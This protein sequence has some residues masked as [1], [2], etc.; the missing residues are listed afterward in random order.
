LTTTL[1]I[2]AAILVVVIVV[3]NTEAVETRLLFVTVSMPRAV[4]LFTTTLLG[5]VIGLLAAWRLG[6]KENN[7][8]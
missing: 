3:Q 5:F 6:R 4:L 8:P 7:T 1:L 2:V